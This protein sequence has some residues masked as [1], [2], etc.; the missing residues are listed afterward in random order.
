MLETIQ[1]HL[2]TVP[3]RC[4]EVRPDLNVP[5]Q[6][7]SIIARCLAK[8]PVDRYQ[9]IADV[10]GDLSLIKLAELDS[11]A[12]SANECAGSGGE[13]GDS[14]KKKGWKRFLPW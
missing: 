7:D 9:S 2:Y 12:A 10:R 11:A 4:R 1:D 6:L 14:E 13:S 5:E 8:E 3:P